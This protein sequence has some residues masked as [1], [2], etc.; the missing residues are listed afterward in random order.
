MGDPSPVWPPRRR[1][2]LSFHFFV[3]SGLHNGLATWLRRARSSLLPRLAKESA[4]PP[5]SSPLNRSSHG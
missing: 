3:H 2:V 4:A 5:V 1:E